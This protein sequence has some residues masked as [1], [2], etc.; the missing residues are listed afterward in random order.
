MG[1]QKCDHLNNKMAI[2]KRTLIT[3]LLLIML[4]SCLF[5]LLRKNTITPPKALTE[6]MNIDLPQSTINIPITLEITSLS[7]YLN[8]KITGEFLNTTL[9]LQKSKKERI[10]LT[11]TKTADITISSTG[12]ELVCILPLTVEATLIDSRVGKTLS[13]LVQPFRTSIIMTLSTPINL[14]RSWKLKTR[15]KIR[16]YRWVTEPVIKV[17]P[18]RKNIRKHLDN[19]IRM[20]SQAL[21]TMVDKEINKAASL[22]KTVAGVWCD[23]QE[24]ILINRNPAPIWIRFSCND[25]KGDIAL[26]QRAII[27]FAS[28]KAKMLI[29]TDTTKS[30]KHSPLPNFKQMEAKEKQAKSDIFVYANTSFYEIN[31]QLNNLLKGTVISSKGY[32]ITIKEVTAYASTEGLTIAVNTGGDLKGLFYLT[33]RPVFD[34]STQRLNVHDFNFAIN[35]SSI[36]VNRGDDILHDLLRERVASKLN[37]GLETLI[38]KLPVI[39]N[40]AIAREKTGRTIDLKVEN[41]EI[42]QCTILMGKE[43]LHF[44]INAGTETTIRLKKIKAG[45][46]LHIR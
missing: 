28:V 12:R 16:G 5:I 14:D 18:F 27:C 19:S 9:F 15:F 43:K 21:T 11:L 22:Q 45:K 33:G 20:N 23:L 4:A 8:N 25:I 29:V 46:T 7:D 44:I 39:I 13:M 30:I 38:W 17:G 42:K 2:K 40:Q 6:K 37:L 35:S 1:V 34:I 10:A 32:K 26:Q 31:Q 24:P 3:G 41:L 36:L